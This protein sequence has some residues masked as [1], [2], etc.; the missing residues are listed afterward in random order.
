MRVAEYNIM[1]EYNRSLIPQPL[2][3][4][5]QE[6][7]NAEKPNFMGK[8]KAQYIGAWLEYFD[9]SCLKG[10]NG[11][12]FLRFKILHIKKAFAWVDQ[13]F[14]ELEL[15][16][17]MGWIATTKEILTHLENNTWTKPNERKLIIKYMQQTEWYQY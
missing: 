8:T 9:P 14:I 6:R 7:I 2:L 15:G 3:D 5:E 4:Y 13:H 10:M 12:D 17:G 16:C 11:L 1:R